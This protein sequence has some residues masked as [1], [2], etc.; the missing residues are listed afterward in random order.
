MRSLFGKYNYT[1]R[2]PTEMTLSKICWKKMGY[3]PSY[4]GNV[5]GKVKIEA[6]KI[7]GIPKGAYMDVKTFSDLKIA[8]LKHKTK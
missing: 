6:R 3:I 4:K 1:E 5:N 2:E 8:T 7:F